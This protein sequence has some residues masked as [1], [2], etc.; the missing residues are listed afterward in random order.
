MAMID[1]SIDNS[2]DQFLSIIR[3]T[4]AAVD[5]GAAN[6][7]NVQNAEHHR[8]VPSFV[9]AG[10]LSVFAPQSGYWVRYGKRP[11]ECVL[12]CLLT[13]GLAPMLLTIM[14]I[15][16][17]TSEGPVFFRQVRVG[18]NGDHFRIWKF[19]T[20][21][22]NAEQLLRDNAELHAQHN[23]NWKLHNDPRVTS[24]G[25]FLRKTSLDE[26]PQLFNVITGNMSLIG[27][28]PVQPKELIQQY[29]TLAPTIT[30]V[31]PGMT[32]LWQISGRSLLSYEDRVRLDLLYVY[33]L[34]FF[35]DSR[36][37]LRTLPSILRGHGAV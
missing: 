21:V 8:F 1:P 34:S 31:R 6:P 15:I 30:S 4:L 2:D 33:Q 12:A 7:I 24:I 5:F 37:F 9:E 16:K 28:R 20:M 18:Q 23:G 13:L 22:T 10:S 32:G 29:G 11:V 27:P 17:L 36:I 26:L 3:P 19:R 25:A 14:L 35:E